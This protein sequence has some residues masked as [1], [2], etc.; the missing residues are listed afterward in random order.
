M[1]RSLR[2]LVFFLLILLAFG[3][4]AWLMR[5]YYQLQQPN[6][7]EEGTVLLEEIN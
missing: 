6:A 7:M 2:Y 3:G 4:G 1:A 5:Y